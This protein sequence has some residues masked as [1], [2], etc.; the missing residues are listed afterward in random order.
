MVLSLIKHLADGR[1]RDEHFNDLLIKAHKKVQ[2]LETKNTSKQ[3]LLDDTSDMAKLYKTKLERPK[4]IITNDYSGSTHRQLEPRNILAAIKPFNPDK[5]QDF[6]DTWR[7]IIMY[8]RRLELT[9]Q[10]FI[11]ILALVT[12]GDAHTVVHDL[13]REGKTLDHILEVMTSLY[14]KKKTILDDMSALNKFKRKANESIECAMSRVAILTEK[15]KP[16]YPKECWSFLR[17][18]IM[19]SILKQIISKNTRVYISHEEMK[20]FNLGVTLEYKAMLNMID[21]YETANQEMPKDEVGMTADACSGVPLSLDFN[22]E[23]DRVSPEQAALTEK[24]KSMEATINELSINAGEFQRLSAKEMSKRDKRS[25]YQKPISQSLKNQ[26]QKANE[27]E[28]MDASFS[29]P[30]NPFSSKQSS[31]DSSYRPRS[32]STSFETRQA[33]KGYERKRDNRRDESRDRGNRFKPRGRSDYK[34]YKDY[35]QNNRDRSE[36]PRYPKDFNKGYQSHYNNSPKSSHTNF[37]NYS[38]QSTPYE[39][40][41]QSYTPKSSDSSFQP[42]SQNTSFSSNKDYNSKWYAQQKYDRRNAY[43]P[44]RSRSWDSQSKNSRQFDY[45]RPRSN[46]WSRNQTYQQNYKPNYQRNFQQQGQRS[47]F[48]QNRYQNNFQKRDENLPLKEMKGGK[49]GNL[50]QFTLNDVKYCKCKNVDCKVMHPLDMPC[51]Y[52]K[53]KNSKNQ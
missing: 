13:T 28:K 35:K 31:S 1:P 23:V 40:N 43:Q 22:F 45:Q 10:S 30:E 7:H 38:P 15:V 49:D 24:I 50:V 20:Y 14:C 9:E 19:T 26:L 33:G 51:P 17:E 2:S 53:N 16:F 8:T 34:D 52:D 36:G 27:S 6:N 18:K 44:Y 42:R 37:S 5:G 11:D 46:S 48:Q 4:V 21:T 3:H 32:K 12:E 47:N 41:S 29:K 39:S 25:E